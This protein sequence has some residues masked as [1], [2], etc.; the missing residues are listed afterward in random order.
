MNK[1]IFFLLE[2]FLLYLA[3]KKRLTSRK[4]DAKI[5]SLEN[6]IY[7]PCQQ[8]SNSS[9]NQTKNWQPRRPKLQIVVYRLSPAQG[10]HM[11]INNH[12]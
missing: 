9:P 6:S 12:H 11:P 3:G 2:W 7:F 8:S 1:N 10:S 5:T 4:N